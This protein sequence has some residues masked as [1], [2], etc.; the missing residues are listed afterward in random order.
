MGDADLFFPGAETPGKRTRTWS[1]RTT[2]ADEYCGFRTW[3]PLRGEEWS[4]ARYGE[5][6]GGNRI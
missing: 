4:Y 5:E 2:R 6:G 1:V 3:S